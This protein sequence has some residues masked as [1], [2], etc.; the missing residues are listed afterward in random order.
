MLTAA[1]IAAVAE[2]LDLY[3]VILIERQRELDRGLVGLDDRRAALS[4][5]PVQDLPAQKEQVSP[6]AHAKTPT[7][8]YSLAFTVSPVN[9]ETLPHVYEACL[10]TGL[11]LQ[12]PFHYFNMLKAYCQGWGSRMPPR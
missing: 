7:M 12:P 6:A 1:A 10:W 8:G 4:I 5:P 11:H 9:T 2:R 3:D